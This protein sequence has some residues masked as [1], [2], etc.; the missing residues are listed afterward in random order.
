M[1][2]TRHDGSVEI[3]RDSELLI[4]EARQKARRRR[5]RIVVALSVMLIVAVTLLLIAGGV[6][7]NSK[8]TTDNKPARRFGGNLSSVATPYFDGPVAIAVSGARVWVVN[9]MGNSITEFDAKTGSQVRVISAKSDA[10][11][12]PD[13][14]A[15]S[16]SHVWVANSNENLGMG[17]GHYDTAKY[18]SVTELNANNGSLVRVID[19]RSDGFLEPGPIVVSGSHVWVLNQNARSFSPSTPGNAL[20]ELN[21]STGS[22]VHV[23]KTNVDGLYGPNG[24]AANHSDVW[25]TSAGGPANSLTEIDSSTGSLVRIIKSTKGQLGVPYSLAVSNGHVW[26]T[27]IH[28]NFNNNDTGHSIAEIDASN[29]SFIRVVNTTAD[30]TSG[31]YGIAV[32]GSHVWITN[33]G[34]FNKSVTELNTD[35][36]SLVRVVGAKAYDFNES[37]DIV[38]GGAKLWVLNASSVTELNAGDGSL[39]RVIK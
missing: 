24:I 2:I 3:E 26:V 38:A 27:N 16:G 18:S 15:V 9:E 25:I 23:F 7:S 14:I 33:D 31:F 11:H 12:H 34:R 6:L 17:G 19:S 22:L 20:I 21:A 32:A 28:D 13:G 30:R 37:T 1:T 39:V 5:L 10:F 29:G 8:Q 36:G 4:K 35:S